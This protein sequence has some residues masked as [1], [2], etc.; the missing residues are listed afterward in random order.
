MIL[1]SFVLVI[2]VQGR[3]C[4]VVYF[5]EGFLVDFVI[6]GQD[7]EIYKCFQQVKQKGDYLVYF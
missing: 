7:V 4:G 3:R 2:K 6:V 1:G 5:C